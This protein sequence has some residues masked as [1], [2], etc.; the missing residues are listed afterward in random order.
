MLLL[1]HVICQA[2]LL[3][4]NDIMNHV[5]LAFDVSNFV[6][7]VALQEDSKARHLVHKEVSRGH[8]AELVPVIEEILEQSKVDW[9][10]LGCVVTTT[11]PGSFTGLRVGLATAKALSLTSHYPVLGI[12][13]FEFVRRSYGH[14][15][16]KTPY[17]MVALQSGREDAYVQLYEKDGPCGD[18]FCLKPAD[19]HQAITLDA[20]LITCIGNGAK[21]FACVSGLVVNCYMP[22]AEDLTIIAEDILSSGSMDDYLLVPY[23]LKAADVT[24]KNVI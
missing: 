22:T 18:A 24:V 19:W 3:E 13:N 8:D 2:S 10:T 9:K 16:T 15:F 21:S 1:I 12:N 11:G 6:F 14:D 23:Y 17:L 4:V 5:I 7:S 20:S